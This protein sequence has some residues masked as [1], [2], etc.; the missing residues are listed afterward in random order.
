M[1][2]EL[3]KPANLGIRNM[4]R[5][6]IERQLIPVLNPVYHIDLFIYDQF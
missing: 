6:P 2:S 5:V 4:H 1:S 3:K